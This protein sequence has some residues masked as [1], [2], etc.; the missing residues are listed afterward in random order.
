MP[1]AHRK[2]IGYNKRN[3]KWG[4]TIRTEFENS[5]DEDVDEWLFNDAPRNLRLE[6]IEHIPALLERLA[7]ATDRM[8]NQVRTSR[9]AAEHL[10]APVLEAAGVGTKPKKA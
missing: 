4:I 2:Y 8:T 3:G 6:V 7:A 10:V 1:D 9:E 5:H